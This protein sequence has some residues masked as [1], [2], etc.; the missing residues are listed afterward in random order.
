MRPTTLCF[1][2]R[3][4]GKILLGR[5]K[6]GFGVRKWNGFGGKIEKG[7][8]FL[9]CAVREL[10]EETGLIAKKEDLQLIGFLDFH[11][12]AAP[13]LDHIG[14][15]YFLHTW[16]GSVQETEEMEPR[17]FAPEAFPYEEMW[18]GDRKWIP[19]LLKG[20]KVKGRVIFAPDQE[21]VQAMDVHAVAQL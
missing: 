4:D 11:F 18:Q 13:E 6:R 10:R 14:F 19:L 3:A 12:A 17:W 5:K 15:V 1:P 16:S 2:V 7:E 9:D 8:N 21:T 20:E